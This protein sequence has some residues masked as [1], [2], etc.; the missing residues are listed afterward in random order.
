DDDRLIEKVL[1]A[2]AERFDD[3]RVKLDRGVFNPAR[4][5]KLYGT[6]AAKGDDTRARPHR[7]SR[8]L[9]TPLTPKISAEPLRAVVK[10][11]QPEEPARDAERADPRQE[12]FKVDDFLR[13][14]AVTVKART[15]ENDGT[16]KWE[17]AHCPF[18]HDHAD[19]EAAVFQDGR[20][21]LGFKCF[22]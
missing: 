7:L 22:H 3:D 18:N 9:K 21:K 11:L 4:I 1:A 5:L 8:I 10:E 15:T 16:I 20:G 14:H 13:S 6:L 17:L 12:K 2:L 19:G